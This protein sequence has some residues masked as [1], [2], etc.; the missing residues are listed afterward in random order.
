MEIADFSMTARI[1][2]IYMY[3]NGKTRMIVACNINEN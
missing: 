2:V 1:T 3:R